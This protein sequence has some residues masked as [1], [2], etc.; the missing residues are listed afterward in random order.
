M[1]KP[2]HLKRW[3]QEY[4]RYHRAVIR[5]LTAPR[6]VMASTPKRKSSTKTDN[7]GGSG[8]A[9]LMLVT[10]ERKYQS[11]RR[12]LSM[13]HESPVVMWRVCFLFL[14]CFLRVC[15]GRERRGH[16]A[17]IV[18]PDPGSGSGR[19]TSVRADAH[20]C[21]VYRGTV[22]GHPNTVHLCDRSE[23]FGV[24]LKVELLR[25]LLQDPAK[26]GPAKGDLVYIFANLIVGVSPFSAR[27]ARG[28]RSRTGRSCNMGQ[29]SQQGA[30]CPDRGRA[31]TTTS[32][33]IERDWLL[34]SRN[35]TRKFTDALERQSSAAGVHSHASVPMLSKIGS[36][37]LNAAWGSRFRL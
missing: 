18:L 37:F 36:S 13:R 32:A 9:G 2:L 27:E 21:S 35:M 14:G 23:R 25:P 3:Q 8:H 30:P 5:A 19:C 31:R 20:I 6:C 16:F 7:G 24:F 33:Q 4:L 10:P 34:P 1:S 26:L 15:E 11:L 12:S 22:G 28:V 29:D 17:Q